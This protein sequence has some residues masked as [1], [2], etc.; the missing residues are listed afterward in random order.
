M[1]REG[2][3]S[4][5]SVEASTG[6]GA[7][8]NIEDTREPNKSNVVVT[9]ASDYAVGAT[10]MQSYDDGYH[11]VAFLSIKL[12]GAAKNYDTRTKEFH[13]IELAAEKWY[14]LLSGHSG[15]TFY[16]DPGTLENMEAFK[17]H[18]FRGQASQVAWH[19]S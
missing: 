14:Y 9:D 1:A 18:Q 4:V 16:S 12:T 10:L 2:T 7:G 6:L 8:I 17:S 19:N 15:T 5:R 3:A 11:P 13:A